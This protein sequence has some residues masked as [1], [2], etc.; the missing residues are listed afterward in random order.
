M[1]TGRTWRK[2]GDFGFAL[3][4]VAALIG[5]L[6]PD[7]IIKWLI[8]VLVGVPGLVLEIVATIAYWGSRLGDGREPSAVL[9]RQE[10]VR[11]QAK[12]RERARARQ[13]SSAGD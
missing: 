3:V 12:A 1:E 13:R 9:R 10:R 2:L 5:W 6:A 4:A 8:V 7:H 11:Q